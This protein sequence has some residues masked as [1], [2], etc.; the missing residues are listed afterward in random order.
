MAAVIAGEIVAG[1]VVIV[2]FEG[3]AGGP[4]MQEMLAITGALQGRG[5][6]NSVAFITDGRFSGKCS[7]FPD[8]KASFV[9]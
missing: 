5:L 4:G 7:L 8:V 6:G 1:D 2:R 3:P 9:S